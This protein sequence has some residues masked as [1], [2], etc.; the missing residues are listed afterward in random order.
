MKARVV[1]IKLLAGLVL[2]SS[3]LLISC[4]KSTGGNLTPQF[5]WE[6]NNTGYYQASANAYT[7]NIEARSTVGPNIKHLEVSL[8]SVDAFPVGAYTMDY[9]F[10][11]VIG[12][13]DESSPGSAVSSMAGTFS[14]TKKVDNR[15][16]GTFDV[17]LSDG[18]NLSGDFKN[19]ELE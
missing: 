10:G 15:I 1:S 17:T 4:E 5:Q 16:S 12:F 11:N 3:L 19:L 14:V 7:N 8:H 2:F 9:T 18:T 13:W 6:L